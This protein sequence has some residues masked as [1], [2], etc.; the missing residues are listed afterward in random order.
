MSRPRLTSLTDIFTFLR[1]NE[2]PVYFVTPAPYNLLGIDQWIGSFELI[3]YFDSFDGYHPR[4]VTPPE[5]GPREFKSMEEVGNYL[6]AHPDFAAR[7]RSRGGRGKALLIMFD[8][9]TER[10]VEALGLELA[11]PPAGLRTHIDS[12]IT[13]TRLGNEAGVPSAPNCMGRARSFPEL[14]RLAAEHGLGSDLV[15][16]TPYG[17]SG[18]TTFFIKGEADWDKH[19]DRMRDEQLKVMKRINHL[20]GTVEGC[21]TRHGTL[22]GPIMTDITGFAEVTPY[23]G[24]WCGND[25]SPRVLSAAVQAKVRAM[26]QKLGQRLWQEGYKGVFCCDFLL[27]TDD[28]AVYL[29]EINPRISGASPPTNLITST[30]GGCP[31]F[32]FHML[33]FLDVDWELDLEAVQARWA[34][35]DAWSQLILK[36]T[37]DKVELITKA[38]TSGIWRMSQDGTVHF[39][40]RAVQFTSVGDEREAFYLR[41]YGVGQYRYYGADLGILVTRGRL[42]TDDRRLTDRAK[43]WNAGI[44]AQFDGVPPTPAAPQPPADFRWM[45]IF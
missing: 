11:L 24:G 8:E 12:K 2:T 38:P 13:T 19:A 23:K 29:G 35:Y 25:A 22:V 20:P 3:T 4:C 34:D 6:L 9:E 43:L 17:D 30:Y 10:L 28:E 45:K 40:R 5:T 27:D 18:R 44:K 14:M 21:A 33:E 42:Q 26:V 31:L 1:K 37:E 15:V 36:Q 39:V 16:Q 32:L 7:V 41:V